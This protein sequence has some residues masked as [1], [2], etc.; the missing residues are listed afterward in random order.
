MN[1][2]RIYEGET[3]HTS[4]PNSS[5]YSMTPETYTLGDAEKVWTL[6]HYEYE[7]TNSN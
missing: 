6:S 4:H 2:I 5:P 7:I 1:S 3:E